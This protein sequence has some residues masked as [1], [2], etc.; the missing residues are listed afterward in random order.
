MFTIGAEI[1]PYTSLALEYLHDEY[2]DD[3]SADIVTAQLALE[4]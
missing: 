1:L 2:E 4:F 3:D